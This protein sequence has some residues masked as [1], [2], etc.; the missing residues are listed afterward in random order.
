MNIN[1][2]FSNDT[3][4]LKK[5]LRLEKADTKVVESQVKDGKK[6]K[7]N[8]QK[9][10]DKLSKKEGKRRCKP[11]REK[12]SD[13]RLSCEPSAISLV[14]FYLC[15]IAARTVSR[16]L[17][18]SLSFSSVSRYLP[19]FIPSL[20]LSFFLCPS[21]LS[22]SFASL[23]VCFF[24]SLNLSLSFSFCLSLSLCPPSSIQ[25]ISLFLSSTLYLFPY[26]TIC[27]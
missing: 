17:S 9:R 4:T 18:V 11:K 19:L 16:C 22:Q 12:S 14:I 2:F 13:R 23:P 26:C 3:C 21:N 20:C 10:S 6:Q 5:S 27:L 25:Y 15:P 1:I 24:W 7:N 8:Y